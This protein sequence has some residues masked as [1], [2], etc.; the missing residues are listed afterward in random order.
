MFLYLQELVRCIPTEAIGILTPILTHCHIPSQQHS[1]GPLGTFFPRRN[2]KNSGQ[3]SSPSSTWQ[4]KNIP[5]PPRPMIQMNIPRTQAFTNVKGVDKEFDM[6]VE[7]FYKPY[8]EFLD[9]FFRAAVTSNIFSE[10]LVNLSLVTGVEAV[11][12]HFNFFPTF[13]VGIN[14]NKNT[15]R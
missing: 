15:Q 11:G 12:W 6:A 8:H 3:N 1:M 4:S 10:T 13:W 5:R 14:K 9:I 2:T 7:R